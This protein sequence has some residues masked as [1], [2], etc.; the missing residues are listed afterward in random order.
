MDDAKLIPRGKTSTKEATGLRHILSGVIAFDHI[1]GTSVTQS[2]RNHKL[3]F[4]LI[5]L[6]ISGANTQVVSA[7]RCIRMQSQRKP[8][9]F[10]KRSSSRSWNIF[11][12]TL[13]VWQQLYLNT[14]KV[15]KNLTGFS[16]QKIVSS[17]CVS[18]HLVNYVQSMQELSR[19]MLNYKCSALS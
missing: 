3:S 2:W 12:P 10:S 5:M 18:N 16:L 15:W 8:F 4:S 1:C 13:M 11:L 7:L 9:F 19:T 17:C 14:F 6:K